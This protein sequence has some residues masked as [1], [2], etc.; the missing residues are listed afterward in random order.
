MD[1]RGARRA[2]GDLER[3]GGEGARSGSSCSSFRG[4]RRCKPLPLSEAERGFLPPARAGCE[5]WFRPVAR[6]AGTRTSGSAKVDPVDPVERFHAD[7]LGLGEAR[8]D[9]RLEG[10]GTDVGAGLESLPVGAVG[11]EARL[12]RFAVPVESGEPGGGLGPDRGLYLRS[13]GGRL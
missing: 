12:E 13:I 8:G 10:I 3:A 9:E 11:G 1:R 4:G 5:D 2:G 6:R 7:G